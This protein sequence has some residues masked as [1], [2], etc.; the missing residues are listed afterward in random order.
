MK[1]KRYIPSILLAMLL[2][3]LPTTVYAKELGQLTI[4]GPGIQGELKITDSNVLIKLMDANF[5]NEDNILKSA[6]EN[7]GQ[8]Y[9]ITSFMKIEGTLMPFLE[10]VYYSIDANTPGYM[11]ITGRLNGTTLHKVNEWTT[12]SPEADKMFRIVMTVNKVTL[13]SAVITA[14]QTQAEV[15]PADSPVPASTSQSLYPTLTF[16]TALLILAGVTLLIRRRT[17]KQQNT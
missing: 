12:I 15:K 4:T 8:G 1:N 17:L 9:V 3:L 13:Q 6:P 7:L 14:P 5:F 2:L 16:V 11:N 10:M